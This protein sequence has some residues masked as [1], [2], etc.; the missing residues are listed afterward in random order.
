[1][2]RRHQ[3]PPRATPF[4][5]RP[6]DDP[7]AHQVEPKVA[8]CGHHACACDKC[9]APVTVAR[10]FVVCLPLLTT[11]CLV[12]NR[13]SYLRFSFWPRE[14]IAAAAVYR[15]ADRRKSQSTPWLRTMRTHR[16]ARAACD[17]SPPAGGDGVDGRSRH[18]PDPCHPL[19]TVDLVRR[20]RDPPAH[21]LDLPWCKR[22]AGLQPLDLRF[23]QLVG[24]RQVAHFLLETAD[25]G[26]P[27]V[28]RP[29]S[30]TTP[31]QLPGRRPSSRSGR[32][33]S[34][35]AGATAIPDPYPVTASARR[36]VCGAP[37]SVVGSSG[38]DPPPPA[39]CA[40]SDGPT[41]VPTSSSMPSSRCSLRSRCTS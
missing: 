9:P 13:H 23:E 41:P 21:R 14:K 24:H 16:A 26:V 32:R 25:L 37:T 2:P 28:R 17:R 11:T 18:A 6:I 15:S 29:G 39:W 4:S 7:A 27:S 20:G 30:S 12:A 8:R 5:R 38:V 35:R 1:M 19:Q 34:P 22:A 33:R 10:T 40:R 36:P 31:R 3:R